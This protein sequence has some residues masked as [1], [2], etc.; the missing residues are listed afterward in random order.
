MVAP[1]SGV[2]RDVI[3]K[4]GEQADP[5]QVVRI[6]EI[7][8]LWVETYLPVSSIGLGGLGTQA[9]VVAEAPD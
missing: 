6:A 9:T 4:P 2:V 3:L 1:V 5:P 7:D 8:P